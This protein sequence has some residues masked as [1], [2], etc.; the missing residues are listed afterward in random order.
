MNNINQIS[1]IIGHRDT[2]YSKVRTKNLYYVLEWLH[3]N[4]PELEIILVEQ[5]E[6][7]TLELPEYVKYIHVVNTGFFNR[8]WTFNIAFK[9]TQKEFLMC[10]DNDVVMNINDLLTVFG[11]IT[12]YDAISPNN[13]LMDLTQDNTNHLI[14]NKLNN[15]NF[16]D[17]IRGGI[18]FSSTLVAFSRYGYEKIFGWDEDFRGWGGEDDIQ[19]LKIKKMLNFKEYDFMAYHMWHERNQ[20]LGEMAFHSNYNNNVQIINKLWN[21]TPEQLIEYYKPRFETYGNPLKYKE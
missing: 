5:S 13:K 10:A 18:N 1:Y 16:N 12:N 7:K 6:H 3:N 21:Y 9:N 4:F 19:T 8:S 11:D 20:S 15:F 2:S 17:I 14:S